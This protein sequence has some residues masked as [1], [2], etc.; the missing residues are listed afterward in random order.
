[1]NTT[2][3]AAVA[4]EHIADLRRAAEHHRAATTAP[5]RTSVEQIVSLR[6]AHS[7]D[8]HDVSRLV[9]LDNARALAAPVMLAVV[10]GEAVAALSL[11]DGRVVA[12]PFVP[13]E[14]AVTLLRLRAT[15][16][17]GERHHR[18]RPRL[19]RSRPA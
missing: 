5:P 12:N 10:D 18:W 9:Q 17:S 16:L 4:S 19:L 2:I 7:E 15:Q 14:Q 11:S 1:M 3:T 8:D 6:L 13:T